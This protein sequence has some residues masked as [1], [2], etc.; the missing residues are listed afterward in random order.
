MRTKKHFRNESRLKKFV[1][2]PEIGRAILFLS[3]NRPDSPMCIRIYIFNLRNLNLKKTTQKTRR[4][5]TKETKEEKEI[6]LEY[7]TGYNDVVFEFALCT[8]KLFD[9][10]VSFHRLFM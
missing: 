3:F 6:L 7:L 4:Q 10:V 9:R 1:L 5:K 2:F 8:F